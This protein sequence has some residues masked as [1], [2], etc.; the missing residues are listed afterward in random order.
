MGSHDEGS[1]TRGA[2][3]PAERHETVIIGAG[4]AGLAVAYHLRRRGREAVILDAHARVGDNWRRHWDSLRLYSPAR[5]DGLPGMPFPAD[6][7]TF[8]TKDQ[9]ADFLEDYARTFEL[10]VRGGVR[11]EAVTTRNGRYEVVATDRRLEAQNVV[12]A[13]G[14]FGRPSRPAFA[15]D[16]DPRIRQLHSS[17]YRRPSQ[18]QAGPVLVVGASHS[19]ADVAMEAAAGHPTVLAGPSRGQLPFELEGRPMR[20]L[21]PLL[22][23]V[24]G[25]V[26]H[27]RTPVGRKGRKE[28]R[29]HGG[30]LLRYRSGDLSAAGVEWV[31]DRVVGVVDGRPILDGGRVLDVA[32]VVWCTGFRQDFS[33]IDLPVTGDDGWPLEERGVVPSAPGLYFAGLAFQSSFRSM[34]LGGAGRD[35]AYVA[36]HLAGREIAPQ[37]VRPSNAAAA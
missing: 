16:L 24:A 25:S 8:P 20:R 9:V 28:A 21:F 2:P 30:P 29:S 34:L 6:R 27:I 15:A 26:L 22:W 18:L 1:A 3:P 4:Q 7:W 17:D 11:V 14:T 36:R 10:D 37:G 32:N 33:W 19:G 23:F 5:Y 31:T 12:V 35:A 13:S